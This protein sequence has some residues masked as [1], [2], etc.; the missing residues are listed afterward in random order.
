MTCI[1]GLVEH[2]TILMGGDSA[3]SDDHGQQ[4]IHTGQKVFHVGQTHQLLLGCEGSCRVAQLLRYTLQIPPYDEVMDVEVWLAAAFIE[5]V[6][7]CLKSGGAAGKEDEREEGGTFLVGCRGRLFEVQADY[8]ILESVTGYEA[9]GSGA[10]IALGA[11]HATANLPA[12]LRIE[13]AL[14]AAAAHNAYVRSPFVIKCL[15]SS[16]HMMNE[17]AREGI[18]RGEKALLQ[19]KG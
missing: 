2:G 13:K 11:L 7:T 12:R 18:Q 16:Q 1:V 9:V 3:I 6:R 8:S 14:A 17:G 5:A 4:T 15:E 19:Q 10:P